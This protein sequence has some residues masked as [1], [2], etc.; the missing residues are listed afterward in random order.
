MLHCWMRRTAAAWIALATLL[1]PVRAAI[2]DINRPFGSH[3]MTYAAGSIRPDHVSQATLDQAVRDFY[4]S[5]KAE[6]LTQACGAGR[7]VVLT[8]TSAGNLTVSEG[9]GYGMMLVALMA[10]HDPDTQSI[11]DGMVAYFRE[12]PTATHDHLMSWNQSNSCSNAEGNDSATDGD[13]DIAFALLLADKQWGS[14]GSI[15]YLGE[16]MLVL[17]DVLD[18]EIDATQSFTLL[19]DWVNAGDA[20]YDTSTRSSDFMVDHFASFAN[21]SGSSAWTDLRDSLYSIVGSLQASHSAGVGLVPD[22][23]VNAATSPAPAAAGFLEGA[24]DGMYSYNACRVPWRLAT[25]YV[26][27]GDTRA[28]AALDILNAWIRTKTGNDPSAIG[29]G[30][31]LDGDAIAGTDYI[32]LAFIA[33]FGVGAMANPANQAWL[34]DTWDYVVATPLS[35]EGYYE[36]SLK[37]LSMIVM[38]GN[39][40]AP[41]T[42]GAPTCTPAGTDECTNPASVVDASV[43]LRRLDRGPAAQQMTLRGTLFFPGGAPAALDAGAQILVEDV[44]AGDAAL[45]ELTEATIP[46][47]GSGDP[48]CDVRDAWKSTASRVQYR[49]RSSALDAPACTPGSANG[50]SKI[51]YRAGSATDVPFTI[52]TKRSTIVAPV[53][54][55]RV[56]LVLGDTAAAGAAGDCGVSG[57]L[58]CSVDASRADCE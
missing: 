3:P 30:Y 25:D 56:T 20:P 16:A 57:P 23:I 37:L 52:R 2:A 33:P 15:D 41:E 11:F 7:Y 27:S 51:Q 43:A 46:V 21:A 19:G 48:A 24:T 53:G 22:F 28:K 35:A 1:G 17:G 13:L 45:F 29:A 14:C 9:H 39:W 49:N 5:W 36:N 18:G 58:D 38:S 10:G 31:E 47:P 54:P 34:N 40:W 26:T 32:S 12:H 8:N 42:V 44:G 4:D 55:L 50:L 6:Y